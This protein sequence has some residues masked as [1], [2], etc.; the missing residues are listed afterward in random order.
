VP[1]SLLLS[2]VVAS[3][4]PTPAPAAAAAPVPCVA[5]AP[6]SGADAGAASTLAVVPESGVQEAHA[7][8][9]LS[10]RALPDEFVPP[11]PAH[12]LPKLRRADPVVILFGAPQDREPELRLQPVL[13]SLRGEIRW[14]IECAEVIPARASVR[15]TDAS[16]I[17]VERTRTSRNQRVPPFDFACC[18]YNHCYDTNIPYFP[19]AGSRARPVGPVVAVWPPDA[20]AELVVPTGHAETQLSEDE[21]HAVLAAGGRVVEQAFRTKGQLYVTANA[22]ERGMDAISWLPKPYR[23]FSDHHIIVSASDA[24]H[25]GQAEILMYERWRNNYGLTVWEPPY[26]DPLYRFSCG[27][28]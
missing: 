14:S 18:S 4:A 3:C 13:C 28:I 12:P 1:R 5:T 16:V 21:S 20:D 6:S 24:N 19:V 26:E 23:T 22:G 2:L 27:T 8:T 11:P 17:A 7:Q 15:L 9:S 10:F 25:D